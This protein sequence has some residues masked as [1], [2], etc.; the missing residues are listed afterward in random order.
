[1]YS[2]LKF[3][4]F[5]YLYQ[6]KTRPTLK[7]PSHGTR[8]DA[9]RPSA[10]DLRLVHKQSSLG[11]LK[12]EGENFASGGIKYHWMAQSDFPVMHPLWWELWEVTVFVKCCWFKVKSQAELSRKL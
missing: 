2:I 9:F 4:I 5:F 1:M 7:H 12:V 6:S 10:E 3:Y 8:A 11:N